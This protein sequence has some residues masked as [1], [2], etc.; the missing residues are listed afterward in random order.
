M[1]NIIFSALLC[2]AGTTLVH[3]QTGKGNLF[4]GASI[5]SAAYSSASN[6][7]DYIDGN[8][9]TTDSK[10]YA[11]SGSPSLGVFVN[12]HLIIGGVFG[13]NYKHLKNEE[14]T[15]ETA[16][17]NSKTATNTFTVDL[18]PFVRYY[19]FQNNPS[20][21]LL[22]LQA[23]AT[24]GTGSG[25][26]AGS[27]TSNSIAYTSS[28]KVSNIFTYT[29][30]GSIGVTHFFQKTVG[31]DLGIGYGYAHEKSTN[32]NN[33]YKTASSGGAK[34][35]VTNDYDLNTSTNGLTLSAGFHW[36]IPGKNKG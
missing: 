21:T 25:N 1:K 20:S 30:G 15:T 16:I 22:Y 19:F 3:A 2:A 7:Y 9:K 6:N 12:D 28:G 13:L 14:N 5:G 34:T 29:G 35:T 26:T 18:G 4:A 27:G 10:T 32:V 33:Q 24:A 31:L 11:I 8:N 23:Q 36:F 17:L